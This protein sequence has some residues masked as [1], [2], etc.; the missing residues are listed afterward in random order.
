MASLLISDEDGVLLCKY[1]YPENYVNCSHP[2]D[3]K[4]IRTPLNPELITHR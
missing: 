1:D 4:P 2:D 3:Y